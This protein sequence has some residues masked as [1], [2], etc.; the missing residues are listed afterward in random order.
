MSEEMNNYMCMLCGY[1]YNELNGDPVAGIDPG[2]RFDAL[3]ADWYCPECG[4][5]KGLF[6]Q[7]E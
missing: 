6:E 2:T 3:P 1:I 5:D 7:T 4:A